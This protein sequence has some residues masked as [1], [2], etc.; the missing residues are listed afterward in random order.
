[1][2][3]CHN[4]LTWSVSC[5][6]CAAVTL[7]CCTVQA[8]SLTHIAALW[9]NLTNSPI[10]LCLLITVCNH[11]PSLP[12]L[13]SLLPTLLPPSL[14]FPL[15]TECFHTKLCEWSLHNA[16]VVRLQV[17]ALHM[18]GAVMSAHEVSKQSVNVHGSCDLLVFCISVSVLLHLYYLD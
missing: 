6:G 1:M 17:E 11:L 14:C 7:S 10:V 5:F 4:T 9:V 18:F 13:P 2:N 16:D 8:S 12:S 3:D 15:C